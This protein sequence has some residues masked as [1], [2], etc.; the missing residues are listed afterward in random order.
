MSPNRVL[1]FDM[2]GVLADVRESYREGIIRT[3]RHFSGQTVTRER[4]QDYKNAGGW[5]NDW[6][7]S[8]QICHDFGVEADYG[9]I[10]RYFLD[11]FLGED[12]LIQRETWIPRD[13]LLERLAARFRLAIFTGRLRIELAPTLRRWVPQ[14][15]FDPIVTTED[16]THGKPHPEGL[17]TIARLCPGAELWYVGDTVDDA[18][19]AKAAGI[20][21]IGIA[22]PAN[23]GFLHAEGAVAVVEDINTIEG[24]LP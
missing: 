14:I 23:A 6:A 1:V 19:S 8:Q 7:L 22:S 21:F 9:E 4:I 11:I 10:S 16:V 24:V 12:G 13:G 18:R 15:R 20:P 3:V 5:N 2:D 17:H